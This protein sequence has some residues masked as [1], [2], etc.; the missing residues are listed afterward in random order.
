MNELNR[1]QWLRTAGLAGAL[2]TLGGFR[3]VE[4]PG[5]SRPAALV[6]GAA[7]M[8][9]NEN[10]YGPSKRVR[11]AMIDHFDEVC[12]YPF[13]FQ[14]ELLSR[15]AAKHGVPEDHVIIT[16]GSTEG[17]RIS[18][19]IHGMDEREVITAE[20]TFFALSDYAGKVGGIIHKVPLDNALQHDLNAMSA[21]INSNTSLVFIC[22]PN[23]PTG[24]LLPKDQLW[25]FAKSHAKQ[26]T[27]F[28]DE[29]YF[30][31][32]TEPGYPSAVELVK[33]GHNVIVS[34]T[35]SKVYGLAGIR[36]GYLIAQ[37]EL[38][39]K[40][41]GLSMCGPN[42]LSIFAALEAMSD[43]E[44][45]EFSLQKNAHNK[46]RIYTTLN[47]IGLPYQESHGNFVFFKTGKPIGEVQRAFEARGVL[48]GRPFPPML[49]WC[50]V[51]T[52]TDE[53]TLKFAGALREVLG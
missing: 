4:I 1:R 45:Y 52:G 20:L 18:G 26:A 7:R 32:I 34:R 48:V 50:R 27:M 21:K 12:R 29:A 14:R 16:A 10:P 35:F 38:I 3:N 47:Q 36:V 53:Q 28:I 25:D 17:L 46:N 41:E 37:P 43:Q 23:N 33:E 42:V 6:N 44:F 51:S 30:D 31:Y 2:A 13:S 15:I 39:D 24:A 40:M 11:Q 19:L 9:F 5:E 22:N 8:N 49:D